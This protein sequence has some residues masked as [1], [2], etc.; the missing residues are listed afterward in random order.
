MHIHSARTLIVLRTAIVAVILAVVAL[1]GRAAEPQSATAEKGNRVI[2]DYGLKK[3]IRVSR[4]LPHREDKDWKLICAL[5][6]NSQFQPWIEAEASAG[7]TLTFNGSE[8]L[9][10][11]RLIFTT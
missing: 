9:L 5:P 8:S 2:K 7:K 1:S 6:H 11:I 10:V 4:D 3:Y